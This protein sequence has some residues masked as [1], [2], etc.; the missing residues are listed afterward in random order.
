[1]RL[2]L[3]VMFLMIQAT[4]QDS[5]P[6]YSIF[7]ASLLIV[8]LASIPDAIGSGRFTVWMKQSCEGGIIPEIAFG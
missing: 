1:M 4:T 3:A 2:K 5:S 6:T 8:L 7:G